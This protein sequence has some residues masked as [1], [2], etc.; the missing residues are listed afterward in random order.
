MVG[1]MQWKYSF[2]SMVMSIQENPTLNIIMKVIWMIA[3]TTK[4]DF[5]FQYVKLN[6]FRFVELYN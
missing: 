3:K 5:G 2:Q 1:N 4:W 6:K